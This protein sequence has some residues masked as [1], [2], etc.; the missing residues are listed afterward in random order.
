[1][2]Q[3]DS[4]TQWLSKCPLNF[5]WHPCHQIS[6][7][8]T[9][10]FASNYLN[11]QSDNS[12][13]LCILTT[14]AKQIGPLSFWALLFTVLQ[15]TTTKPV[16]DDHSQAYKACCEKLSLKE[17]RIYARTFNAAWFILSLSMSR[18]KHIKKHTGQ[19]AIQPNKELIFQVLFVWLQ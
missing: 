1:M 7:G 3:R 12:R 10:N 15:Y 11:S 13:Q 8:E 19:Q 18:S 16:W 9:D 2:L 5:L 6:N 17:C 14:R 4:S